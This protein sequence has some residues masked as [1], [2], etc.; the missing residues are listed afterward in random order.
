M[1]DETVKILGL[2]GSLRQA[3]YNRALLRAASQLGP[4][5]VVIEIFDG[6]GLLP[7]FDADVEAAGV[8]ARVADLRQAIGEAD[9]LLI[10][11]PEYNDGTSAVLKNALDWASRG[12]VRI[13]AGKPVAVMGTATG[14]G[15]ARGGIDS[16][17]RTM[18][19]TGAHVVDQTVAVPF[20]IDA[21]DDELVL[22]DPRVRAEVA[23]LVARL[24]EWALT[25]ADVA[26]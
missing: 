8:P 10:A 15:G 13:L 24:A 23:A 14:R 4:A 3:S 16:V 18:R 17:V 20:A 26:A 25:R 5:G 11:T 21:F 9:A 1:V 19:R 2:A 6:L 12:P 22:A 7:F